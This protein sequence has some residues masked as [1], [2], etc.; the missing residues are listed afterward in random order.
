MKNPFALVMLL[1]AVAASA[2]LPG[3]SVL[4][5]EARLVTHDERTMTLASRAGAPQL[6][7]LFFTRCD[8]ACPLIIDTAKQI[9][10]QLTG[11]QRSR[12]RVLLVS[13]DPQRDDP[14]ALRALAA[15]RR[16]DLGR[17]TLAR[18]EPL[19]LRKLAALLDVK[20]RRL[21]SGDFSHTAVLVLLDSAGR[22]LARTEHMG[23]PE[24]AF[25]DAVRRATAPTS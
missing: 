5:L 4:Q 11:P 16:L 24:P 9:D 14:A 22:I 17:W 21:E 8:Y 10:R 1:F 12:L 25:V 2:A 13:L 19:P 18:M 6:V 3:D 15:Q 23:I 7:S 20:Y